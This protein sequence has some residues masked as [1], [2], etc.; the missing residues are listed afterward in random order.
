M[1]K[2]R[3]LRLERRQAREQAKNLETRMEDGVLQARL[4]EN[5]GRTLF[6]LSAMAQGPLLLPSLTE[7]LKDD[8]YSH[9]LKTYS[10]YFLLATL[11]TFAA[12]IYLQTRIRSYV[13]PGGPRL[14]TDGAWSM[15]RHPIYA[16]MRATSVGMTATFP[17]VGSALATAGLFVGTEI[18]ARAEE[19]KLEFQVGEQYR[20]YEVRVPRWIPKVYSRGE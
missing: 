12:T 1:G 7:H 16:G 14:K 20:A 5:R 11:T 13:S 18:A 17:S 4:S 8:R 10:P 3:R 15:L 6:L 2:Q 9:Y 19:R